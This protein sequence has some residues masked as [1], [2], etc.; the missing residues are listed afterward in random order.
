MKAAGFL[1]QLRRVGSARWGG[2]LP[3]GLPEE[4]KASSSS[5]STVVT[6]D[7]SSISSTDTDEPARVHFCTNGEFR[8]VDNCLYMSAQEKRSLWYDRPELER[9]KSESRQTANAMKLNFK[10]TLIARLK[11]CH[12]QAIFIAEFGWRGDTERKEVFSSLKSD[13]TSWVSSSIEGESCRGMEKLLLRRDFEAFALDARQQAVLSNL[14]TLGDNKGVDD[15]AKTYH[16]LSRHAVV[17]A[18]AMA[19]ADA[20]TVTS[21]Y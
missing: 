8:T 14:S 6:G 19:N 20:A 15:I 16:Y 1:D 18:Q 7:E 21:S 4:E 10:D 3:A 11:G 9:M 2:P 5:H 13:L 17:F 12:D